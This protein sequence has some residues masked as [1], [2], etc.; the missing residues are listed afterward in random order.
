MKKQFLY[1]STLFIIF[2]MSICAQQDQDTAVQKKE[3]KDITDEVIADNLIVQKSIAVGINAVDGED[4]GFD[5]FRLKENNIRIHFDDTSGSGSFPGNDWRIVINDA[6]NGGANYFGIEDAT[7]DIISFKILAGAPANAFFMAANGNIGL[8]TDAPVVKLHIAD[9]NSPVL[10]IEQDAS[11]GFTPQIWDIAGNEANFFIR[12]VTNGSTLPFRIK[13][14]AP[15]NALFIAANGNIGLGTATPNANASLELKSVNKGFLLNRLTT[16]EKTTLQSLLVAEDI[17]LM[18]YDTDIKGLFSWDGTQWISGVNTDAQDLA[19]TTNTLSL[20]NDG[21]TVDLSGYLDNTDAQD[22]TLTTNTLS[23]TNDGTAVDLSGYLDNI[24]A[25]TVSLTG[26][27]L[28]ISNGNNVDLSSLQ[29]GIGTDAQD[30]T[31]STN[32]L[33]LTNDGTAVDLSG[34][35]DNTDAQTVSLTGTTFAISNG[36]NVDLSSL[37]DGIGTDAQDLTLST[38]TLSLTNDGT[39]VDLSGYL[40]NTDAQDLTLSTNILSLTN[41]GTPVDLSGY[42]DNTDAQT[43]SLTGTTFAISNGN[44]LNLSS[45][46]DGIGTDAQDLSLSTNTLSLTNDG[47]PVDLSGYL[48]NTDAQTVSL[49]GTTLA[50]SNGNNVDLSSL[51]DG[52]GTD[53]Q[54][55]TSA[56]LSGNILEIEIENGNSVSVDLSPV[57]SSLQAEINTQS[58]MITALVARIEAIEACAC[59]GTLAVGGIQNKN[60]NFKLS[61]NKPN[62]FNGETKIDFKIPSD[63]QKAYIKIYDSNGK[64]LQKIA[65]TQRGEGSITYDNDRFSSGLYYYSLFADNIKVNTK[66][67]LLNNK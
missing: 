39:T 67:M 61:Q 48:D 1:L 16:L 43:V 41:D 2:S 60:S 25:Q 65:I 19:L 12:D 4:F 9:G 52:I 5:T 44:T 40:D 28:A 24:D 22:L 49:T 14:G 56:V 10:R 18:V 11:S 32:T 59:G 34:Y 20:T 17:G 50:I 45:L 63:I 55:L 8:G 47:T 33:S 26:T 15:Q 53:A 51:Q 38:N 58:E 35:L 64:I 3:N 54:D 42:L 7:A 31:L 27:T 6:A 37:Q 36:N 13:P 29:D 57:L 30:L 66:K 21:T 62:P 46:Q 23:L